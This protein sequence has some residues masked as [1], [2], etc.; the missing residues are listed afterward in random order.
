MMMMMMI[1][2]TL[3]V[4]LQRTNLG[5]VNTIEL[6]S[7]STPPVKRMLTVSV[8]LSVDAY[9]GYGRRRKC[10]KYA[11]LSHIIVSTRRPIIGRPS[12][13]ADGGLV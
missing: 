2:I 5:Q 8:S 7:R 12:D 9:G 13:A 3:Y 11:A 6:L 10:K 4:K 1:S